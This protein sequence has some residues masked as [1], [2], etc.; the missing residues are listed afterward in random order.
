VWAAGD[1]AGAEALTE[2]AP[3][4]V[5]AL[6]TRLLAG[7]VGLEG[8]VSQAAGHAAGESPVGW[9]IIEVWESREGLERFITETLRPT[10]AEVTGGQAPEF[11]PETFDVHFEGP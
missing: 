6:G 10:V 5:G 7:D 9:R 1:G 2:R 4:N 8:A 3:G 11:E